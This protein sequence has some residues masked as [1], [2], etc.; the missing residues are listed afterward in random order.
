MKMVEKEQGFDE[1]G[2][3]LPYEGMRVYPQPGGVSRRYFRLNQPQI[4]FDEIYGRDVEHMQLRD[5]SFT[6][7]QFRST[8]EAIFEA[9]Y[10]DSKMTNITKGIHV[11]FLCPPMRE[12]ESR[13]QELRRFVAAAGR[14]F[15]NFHFQPKYLKATRY[16]FTDRAAAKERP[17]DILDLAEGSR[18]ERFEA[19]RQNGWVVGWYFP[20]CLSEFD[21]DSQRRQMETLPDKV[22]GKGAEAEIVLSG[23][24]EATAAIAGTPNLLFNE[25]AYPHHLCLS[26]LKDPDERYFYDFEADGH[27]LVFEYRTN[28]L[29]PGYK[30]LS[31]QFAGGLTLFMLVQR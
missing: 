1:F 7:K 9:L 16:D 14:S 27:N 28:V 31:E 23:G 13:S 18:Y 10:H 15:V 20:N 29:F 19:A 24:I 17:G 30:Q 3:R 5:L 6:A 2:R 26:A 12:G 22:I 21:I 8:C 4:D 11:P 25:E